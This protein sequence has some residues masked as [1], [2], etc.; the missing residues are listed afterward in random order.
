MSV[1]HSIAGLYMCV[2]HLK[3]LVPLGVQVGLDGSAPELL[4][5]DL[6][7]PV[8]VRLGLD[9]TPQELV[10]SL[11]VLGLQEVDPENPLR[12]YTSSSSRQLWSSQASGINSGCD[13]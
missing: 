6:Q 11:Q 12:R 8:R 1:L 10:L 7:D 13:S 2:G 5:A 4:G 9:Q 3:H